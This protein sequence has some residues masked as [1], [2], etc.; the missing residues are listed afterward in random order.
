VS[1]ELVKVI[2]QPVALERDP[3]GRIVGEKVGEA[4]SL[5][6]PESLPEFVAELRRQIEAANAAADNGLPQAVAP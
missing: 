2:V 6:T 5:F 3:E 1:L 4:T